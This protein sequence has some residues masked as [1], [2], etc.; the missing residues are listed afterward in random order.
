[1]YIMRICPHDKFC[2]QQKLTVFASSYNRLVIWQPQKIHLLS[3]VYV[4]V[5]SY[6]NP[7]T[8]KQNGMVSKTAIW[9][10]W[11]LSSVAIYIMLRCFSSSQV[12]PRMGSLR[13]GSP[14]VP[15]DPLQIL[16]KSTLMAKMV[17]FHGSVS[18]PEGKSTA[19]KQRKLENPCDPSLVSCQWL[20]LGH[21]IWQATC[22]YG[23]NLRGQ[24]FLPRQRWSGPSGKPLGKT[25][26]KW[27]TKIWHFPYL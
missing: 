26:R 24:K 8:Q 18:L 7:E 11:C 17:M 1:M 25:F 6:R 22:R 15:V 3:P 20:V 5:V 19:V 2:W 21:C 16:Q 12:M 9:V 10:K 27:S 4:V 14:D 23:V 13:W